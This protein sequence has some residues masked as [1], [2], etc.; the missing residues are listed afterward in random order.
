MEFSADFL[1]RVT[2]FEGSTSYMYLDPAGHVT[3]GVGHVIA[4]PEDAAAMPFQG[5][6]AFHDWCRV[7]RALR[8]KLI[9]YYKRCSTC[10][11]TDRGVTTLLKGDLESAVLQLN[12]GVPGFATLPLPVQQALC[13]M[14][15]DLGAARF[16]ESYPALLERVEAADWNGASATCHR[17]GVTQERNDWCSGMFRAA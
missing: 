7:K 13:D 16:L 12:A 5:S 14:A 11:L 15:F 17:D 3:V 9:A 2:T 1:A 8:G 4:S 10:R 6:D